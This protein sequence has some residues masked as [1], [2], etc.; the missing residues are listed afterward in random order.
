MNSIKLNAKLKVL[1]IMF[2]TI[3]LFGIIL[4]L[5]GTRTVERYEDYGTTPY[6]EYI[7]I[8]IREMETRK[9]I[10]D[11]SS[12]TSDHSHVSSTY[13]TQI[14]LTKLKTNAVISNIEIYLAAKTEK[15]YYC[16][17]DY[18]T[19]KKSMSTTSYS[20]IT[21]FSTFATKAYDHIDKNGT[22][23]DYLFN[24]TPVEYMVKINYTVNE[25]NK[26]LTYKVNVENNLKEL[27]NYETRNVID[28][29]DAINANCID[30]VND[31]IKIK[32]LKE[33]ATDKTTSKNVYS[34]I[35]KISPQVSTTNLYN[36]KY[37]D[38]Y[39][40]E[41]LLKGL[42][43]DDT[44]NPLDIY[45]EL[46]EVKLSIY[47]K[48]E[49][50]DKNFSEY[51]KVYSIYGFMSRYVSLSQGRVKLDESLN[52][53]DIYVKIEGSIYNGKVDNFSTTYKTSYDKIA[54]DE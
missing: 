20:S 35:L 39:L 44:E 53:S 12:T 47:A 33:E 50:D 7:G 11:N 22:T 9:S 32:V 40:N 8:T 42:E 10:Y 13:A 46:S 25:E 41:N 27:E 38:D 2:Y 5:F 26:T 16:Y 49:N 29:T 30:P 1:I 31:P 34:D 52:M 3:V 36:H 45:P 51:V 19:S 24:E 17:G 54:A 28:S 23:V 21:S 18:A 4:L 43:R 37:D 14:V 6:D 48:V 15:G